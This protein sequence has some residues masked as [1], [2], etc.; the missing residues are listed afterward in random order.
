MTLCTNVYVMDNADPHEVFHK[1]RELLNAGD[2]VQ[3][4][5]EPAKYYEDGRHTLR[6]RAGSGLDALLW[7]HYKPGE[8]LRADNGC[9]ADCD[10]DC[11]RTWHDPPHWIQPS[12]DTAYGYENEKGWGCGV[13]HASLV[14]QLGMWLDEQGYRW[15]WRNEFSGEVHIGDRYE[16]LYDL[17]RGGDQAKQ[18]FEEIVV[19][20]IEAG[21]GRVL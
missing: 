16:R 18:W 17:F 6:N 3:F 10:D 7:L 15:A 8:P 21:F 9:D 19:P 5:D 11:D 14:T 12:F 20:A 1:C 2:H 13:L 4:T